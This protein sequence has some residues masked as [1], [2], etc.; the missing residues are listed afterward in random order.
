MTKHSTL[1]NP[2]DLHYAKIKTFTGNSGLITPD[3]TDQL[4]SATDT[5]KVYRATSIAQ[6]GLIELAP[7]GGGGSTGA[8]IDVGANYPTVAPTATGQSYFAS[9]TQTLY[10]SVTNPLGGY[11]WQA[12]KDFGSTIGVNCSLSTNI[13]TAS[14][15]FKLMFSPYTTAIDVGNFDFTVI[16]A[17]DIV[18]ND[19]TNVFK[20]Y[21][22]GFYTIGYALDNPDNLPLSLMTSWN[23]SALVTV[24]IEH[25]NSL[26]NLSANGMPIS[27]DYLYYYDLLVGSPS[28]I[29]IDLH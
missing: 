20:E 5:N 18:A 26:Y 21:G 27:S 8:T 19:I 23:V 11:F 1:T 17:A 22:T 14:V 29:S 10:I 3:F 28:S 9:S 4:L 12:T 16:A 13:Q 6:G 24:G 25:R 7:T 15:N 2:N